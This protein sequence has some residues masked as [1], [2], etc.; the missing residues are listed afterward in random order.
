MG[1]PTVS[2]RPIEVDAMRRLVVLLTALAC[3]ACTTT[4]TPVTVTE[5]LG[6]LRVTHPLAWTSVAGPGP[7]T[8]RG[9][10]PQFYL[11]NSTLTVTCS[12]PPSGGA[13]EGCPA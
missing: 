10:V 6:R 4:P 12:P 1:A 11:T 7:V 8:G 3:A 5:Q 2:D 9:L 13:F